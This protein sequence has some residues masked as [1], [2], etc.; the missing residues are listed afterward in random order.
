MGSMVVEYTGMI[1]SVSPY[2]MFKPFGMS[3]VSAP[4]HMTPAAALLMFGAQFFPEV[5]VDSWSVRAIKVTGLDV[6]PFDS[7]VSFHTLCSCALC[8]LTATSALC[9]ING[10][11][12]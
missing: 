2:L 1:V 12:C 7:I 6:A 11:A 8:V 3:C 9:T 5:V 10:S 4:G